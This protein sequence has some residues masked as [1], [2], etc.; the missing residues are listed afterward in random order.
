MKELKKLYNGIMNDYSIR[1]YSVRCECIIQEIKDR[2]KYIPITD[3]K[4]E[5]KLFF[6]ALSVT[7]GD[8]HNN[9]K[10][11]VQELSCNTGLY[12]Y[13]IQINK[14]EKSFRNKLLL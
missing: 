5:L 7:K 3:E 14:I 4:F 10:S 6:D 8:L 13:A 1:R 2:Y 12:N 9:I 11:F